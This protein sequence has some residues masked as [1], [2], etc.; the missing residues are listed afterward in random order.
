M[1]VSSDFTARRRKSIGS[2]PPWM[3]LLIS[4]LVEGRASVPHSMNVSSDFTA[5]RRKSIGSSMDVSSDFTARR[6]KSIGSTPPWVCL[7]ISEGRASVPLLH[8]CVF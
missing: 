6:R 4:L 7:L 1:D 8:G 5:R 2:T 3:C